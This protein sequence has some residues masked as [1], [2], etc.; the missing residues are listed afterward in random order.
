MAMARNDDLITQV[1]NAKGLYVLGLATVIVMSRPDVLN[2][3]RESPV[4]FGERLRVAW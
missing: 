4:E 2:L 1:E 3:L